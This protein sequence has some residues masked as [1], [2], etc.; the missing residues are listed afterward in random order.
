M[1]LVGLNLV[2]ALD[3][4]GVKTSLFPLGPV[5]V[6]GD[7]LPVKTALDRA[8][9]YDPAAPSVRYWHPHELA[10]HVGKGPRLGYAIWEQDPLPAPSVHQLLT[11][12]LVLCPTAW[13][14]GSAER[15]GVPRERLRVVNHGV[16]MTVFYPTPFPAKGPTVFITIGKWEARKGHDV[17]PA[18]LDSA[19]TPQDDVLFIAHCNNPFLSQTE[20]AEWANL[21]ERSRLGRAGKVR[22]SG[23][24]FRTQEEVASLV[25]QAHC[26]VFPSRA[27]GW[28]LDLMETLAMGRHAIATDYAGH[29]EFLT[30]SSARLVEIDESE[31]AYDGRWFDGSGR[32]ARLGERQ[33]EQL[34][35][36]LRDVHRA[37]LE[38][39]LNLNLNGFHR[40]RE[41]SWD[42]AARQL[43]DA[44]S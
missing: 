2:R 36:H 20:N 3:T 17:I 6:S 8:R 38:G 23:G 13:Q 19:F 25:G 18:A 16:D 24:R 7:A 30:P 4:A 14:A 33:L 44:C 37:R 31:A 35:W 43:V 22:V 41:F 11:Q 40:A 5:E 21:Y 1:G 15:M 42:R 27:E 34:V 32:W 29:T 10:H 12:D 26:G 28:G 9:S 39:R